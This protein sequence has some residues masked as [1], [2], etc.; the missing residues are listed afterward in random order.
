MTEWPD[1]ETGKWELL[2]DYNKLCSEYSA[3]P[4]GSFCNSRYNAMDAGYLPANST[5]VE[6]NKD[7]DI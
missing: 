5:P 2:E 7:T 1:P 6:L 4:S 3:C